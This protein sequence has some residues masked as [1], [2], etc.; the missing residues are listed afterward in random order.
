MVRE[1]TIF[2]RR[3]IEFRQGRYVVEEGRIALFGP[4]QIAAVSR[5]LVNHIAARLAQLVT[6]HIEKQGVVRGEHCPE[7][8]VLPLEQ[9]RQVIG[10]GNGVV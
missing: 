1:Q 2:L 5:V 4:Q 8:I 10:D 6:E 9:L 3:Q 7:P